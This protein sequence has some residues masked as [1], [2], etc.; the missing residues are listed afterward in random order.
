MPIIDGMFTQ[1]PHKLDLVITCIIPKGTFFLKHHWC[2]IASPIVK[3]MP[4]VMA[5]DNPQK[6]NGGQ[7]S[8]GTGGWLSDGVERYHKEIH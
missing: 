5:T 4:Q 2:Q 3:K 8:N 7:W 1:G 6:F